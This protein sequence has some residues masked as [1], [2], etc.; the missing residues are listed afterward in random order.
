MKKTIEGKQARHAR[1]ANKHVLFTLYLL[2][3]LLGLKFYILFIFC[4]YFYKMNMVDWLLTLSY[5]PKKKI[6]SYFRHIIVVFFR[7]AAVV[8]VVVV[9]GSPMSQFDTCQRVVAHVLFRFD[10][11][12]QVHQTF[13]QQKKGSF[14]IEHLFDF[15]L[16]FTLKWRKKISLRFYF[17]LIPID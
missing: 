12:I 2:L 8:V 3:L 5:F 7:F 17:K 10:F 13:I 14:R 4:S 15:V 9:V 1:Q 11:R 6:F 16:V